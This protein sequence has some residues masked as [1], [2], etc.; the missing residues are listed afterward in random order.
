MM[1]TK[2][3]FPKVKPEAAGLATNLINNIK[4]IAWLGKEKNTETNCH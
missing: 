3:S 2:V 1:I 4:N